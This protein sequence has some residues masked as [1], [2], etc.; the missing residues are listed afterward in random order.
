VIRQPTGRCHGPTPSPIAR[1]PPNGIA[2]Y[3]E[4]VI[5]GRGCV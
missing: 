3:L 4:I 1:Y 2:R 5:P